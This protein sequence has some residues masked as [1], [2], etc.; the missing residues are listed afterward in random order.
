M[1]P[2]RETPGNSLDWIYFFYRIQQDPLQNSNTL[3][4]PWIWEELPDHS[5][6]SPKVAVKWQKLPDQYRKFP[7]CQNNHCTIVRI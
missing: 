3:N 7:N 1:F 2:L 6:K 4:A 5:G